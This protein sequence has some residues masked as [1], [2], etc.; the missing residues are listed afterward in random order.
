MV[1]PE[2]GVRGDNRASW[3]SRGNLDPRACQDCVD[4]RAVPERLEQE[5]SQEMMGH[6]GVQASREREVSEGNQ[7][8]LGLK[9][10]EVSFSYFNIFCVYYI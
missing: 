2:Y 1:S 7:G 10:L 3:V 5:G 9:A 6:Q 8:N 4:P